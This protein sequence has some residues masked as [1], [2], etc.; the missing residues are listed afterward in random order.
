MLTYQ[1]QRLQELIH[2]IL[3]CC[4]ERMFFESKK[5]GLPQAELKCLMLFE[6]DKYSTAKDIAQKLDVAKSRVTKI[7]DSL[8]EKILIQRID[9][10]N[11]G[12]VK[13]IS[14]TP[15]GQQKLQEIMVFS[16]ELHQ[17]ILRQLNPEQRKVVLNSLELLRSSME[18]VKAQLKEIQ[19]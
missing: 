1:T 11:D 6:Y 3:Q 17:K 8:A 16:K 19:N 9:A 7:I 12:R 14:L 15:S 5:F 13:L 18:A 10:P 4:Q 2:E